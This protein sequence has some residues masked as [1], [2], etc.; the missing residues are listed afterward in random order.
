M[1]YRFFT[2]PIRSPAEGETQLN[3]FLGS[4]RV[5]SIDCKWVES[6]TES[7]WCSC[8]DYIEASG[9]V[10]RDRKSSKKDYKE[11]LS[12]QDFAVYVRLRDLRKTI[13][14]EEAIPVYTIFTNDQLAAMVEKRVRSLGELKAI[15]GV[16]ESRIAKYGERFLEVLNQADVVRDPEASEAGGESV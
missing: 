10:G 9:V 5:L 3:A 14:Q 15:D 12:P 16:G 8:V 1:A 13:S 4:H 7:L 6:G 11:L 2:V